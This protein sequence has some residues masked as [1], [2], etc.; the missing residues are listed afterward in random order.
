MST[1]APPVNHRWT[2]RPGDAQRLAGALVRG[3]LLGRRQLVLSA[4]LS[5]VLVAGLVMV[6]ILGDTGFVY[7]A[8]VG[9]VTAGFALPWLALR[10]ARAHFGRIAFPG[11][12]WAIGYGPANLVIYSPA[13]SAVVGYRQFSGVRPGY[14][15]TV[16]LRYADSR[17]LLVLPDALCPPQACRFLSEAI[18]RARP[19]ARAT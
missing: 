12:Q 17:V 2:A 7:C 15:G 8:M 10:Q 4:I 13:A 3:G 6:W 1:P 14:A 5:A 18:A 9:L 19:A 11:A 16:L